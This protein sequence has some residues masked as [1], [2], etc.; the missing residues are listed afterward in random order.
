MLPVC[1]RLRFQPS[2]LPRARRD[3]RVRARWGVNHAAGSAPFARGERASSSST[4]PRHRSPGASRCLKDRGRPCTSPAG[5]G[6][7]CRD[8][9]MVR[10]PARLRTRG[11]HERWGDTRSQASRTRDRVGRCRDGLK[12]CGRP[13]HV[14]VGRDH[15]SCVDVQL[16]SGLRGSD[17]SARP[18]RSSTYDSFRRSR[19]TLH[20]L[21]TS[22]DQ[23]NQERAPSRAIRCCSARPESPWRQQT[24]QP[25]FTRP[26]DR[27]CD[28]PPD[29]WQVLAGNGHA[30]SPERRVPNLIRQTCCCWPTRRRATA[31]WTFSADGLRALI[32]RDG[33]TMTGLREV[34]G[35]AIDDACPRGRAPTPSKSGAR[36]GGGR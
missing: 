14:A 15:G 10:A 6:R 25:R 30:P 22:S 26:H 19:R 36:K 29:R 31:R 11:L 7:A 20:R 23:P 3:A 24:G 8:T 32:G 12:G 13:A 17:L 18:S 33:E 2:R 4:T 21:A 9:T 1:H 27:Q 16:A 5:N 28:G 35:M 34:S